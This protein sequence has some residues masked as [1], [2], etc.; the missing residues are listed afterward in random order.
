MY[1]YAVEFAPLLGMNFNMN[2]LLWAK[3]KLKKY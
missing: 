1:R 3:A 2:D